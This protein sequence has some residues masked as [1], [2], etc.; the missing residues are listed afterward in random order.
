MRRAWTWFGAVLLT[1][2]A[3]AGCTS[4]GNRSATNSSKD[5][6]DSGTSG[7]TGSSGNTGVLGD[8]G[9]SGTTGDT[10][11]GPANRQIAAALN[12]T[13]KSAYAYVNDIDIDTIALIFDVHSTSQKTIA[14]YQISTALTVTDSLG[15]QYEEK[16]LADCNSP[17]SPGE[18]R[19]GPTGSLNQAVLD[20]ARANCTASTWG[21]NEFDATQNGLWSGVKNGGGSFDRASYSRGI[22]FSDGTSLG[23][24]QTGQPGL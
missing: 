22:A 23:T 10:G 4:G 24:A 13:A 3:L 18:Q 1:A 11:G 20:Q 15:R 14:A 17:L 8:S 5:S 6:N 2:I 7:V 19:T 12:V 9:G 21:M 16:L